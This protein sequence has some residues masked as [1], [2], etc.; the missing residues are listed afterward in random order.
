MLTH[1]QLAD[2]IRVLSI[3]SVQQARSGHPG[4]VMGM[5]DIAEVLWRDFLQHNPKNPHWANRDRFVL[6][7]GHGSM[8]LYS[9]LHLSGYDVN[10]EELKNFRQLESK[11]PG[12][13]EYGDT[14]GVETTTGP[15]GQGIANAVGMALAEKI[16]AAQF[17]RSDFN[18]IDHFTYAFLGDGC[19]M[20]GIS[21]EACSLAGTW[22]LG[23]LI[24]FWDDNK[25]SIDGDVRGWFTDDTAER[26]SAY[27]WHVIRDV[28]GHDHEAVKKA[29]A[30]A[31]GVT[32]KPSIICCKTIIGYGSPNKSG[33]ESSHGE[34]LGEEEIKLVRQELAWHYEP[35]NIPQE[36]YQ[37]WDATSNGEER[38]Q[39]WND[40]FLCYAKQFP[41]LADQL[42]R[43]LAGDFPDD[44]ST[45]LTNFVAA[46]MTAN[47]GKATRK[48]SLKCIEF[49]NKHLPELIGGAADLAGSNCTKGKDSEVIS[50]DDFS[51]NYI[52]YGV[53]EFGMAAIMNG[54][55]IHGGFIPYGGTYLVFSDY[56]RNALRMSALMQQRV[57]YILT[58]DSIG[59]G[60]DG[61]TH[62]PIEQLSSLRLMPNMTV[63]RPADAVETAV[64]WQAALEKNMGPTSLCLTRQG[65]PDIANE[66][67]KLENIKRGAYVLR[68]CSQQAELILIATGSEVSISCAA[69]EIL[70]AKGYQVRVVS[71][72]S[73]NVF[74][75][76]S[77]TYQQSVLPNAVTKRIAI[78]AGSTDFWYK[79]VGLSGKVIGM[80]SFGKSAPY[81]DLFKYFNFTAEHI[82]DVALQ[83]LNKS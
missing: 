50:V 7:N 30:E 4:M 67:I 8:L 27:N 18:V 52:H 36:Y 71:M 49:L 44:F 43:R 21:H 75:Q 28:D 60:E 73:T 41:E 59:L 23:K 35:F 51:G 10:L 40:L 15:L 1:R 64:A 37:A 54:L 12:H 65:V 24:A 68:D 34:P 14:P 9:L 31:R 25:I 19:L 57:I 39:E 69:A 53:R 26:F 66:K 13:P 5:A 72:P 38:E 70:T 6:S 29:I 16:L 45:E 78:E 47:E 32:D 79:Y 56:A 17:N 62:Q 2:V 11:T 76:Q 58:H 74:D 3:D 55:A 33:K 82:V 61:P 83:I 22:K 46:Q 77:E 42:A 20:E 81:Q 80:H 63:W 48:S